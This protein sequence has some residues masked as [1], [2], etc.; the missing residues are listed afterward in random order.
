MRRILLVL[1]CLAAAAFSLTSCLKNDDGYDPGEFYLSYGTVRGDY[2]DF[3]IVLDDGSVLIVS[4]GTT[5][6]LKVRDGQRVMAYY[7]ILDENPVQAG[8]ASRASVAEGGSEPSAKAYYVKLNGL[9]EVTVKETDLLS[10]IDTP[11]KQDSIGHDPLD[12]ESIRLGP[13]YLDLSLWV[14]RSAN[15]SLQHMVCLVADDTRTTED[16]VYL[17]VRHN[18][19]RDPGTL[20]ARGY[21]SFDV[22]RFISPDKAQVTFHI[23]HKDYNGQEVTDTGVYKRDRG[24][25]SAILGL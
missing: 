19:Y 15:S 22:S 12:V 24:L 25:P 11:E 6:A 7:N 13:Q 14:F 8:P 9:Y 17:T 16:D 23:T 21:M 4:A 10:E 20:R 18:A 2:P 3:D 1:C 5:P